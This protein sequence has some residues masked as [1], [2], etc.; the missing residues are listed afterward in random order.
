MPARKLISEKMAE[1]LSAIAHQHRIRIIEELH[2]GEQNV[3]GLQAILGTSHSVVSQHLSILRANKVVKQR[4]EGNQVY[5]QLA[6]PELA[7]WLLQGLAYLEGGLQSDEVIRSA[8][9]EVKT[10]WSHTPDNPFKNGGSNA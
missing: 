7:N 2:T 4:K 9:N 6:Q 8:V 10:I 5:Y 3:N 1:F